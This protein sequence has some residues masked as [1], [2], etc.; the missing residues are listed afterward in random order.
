MPSDVFDLELEF[1]DLTASTED[2]FQ[3]EPVLPLAN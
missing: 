3:G 1:V 2:V